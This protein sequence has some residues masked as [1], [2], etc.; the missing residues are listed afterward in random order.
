M[1]VNIS[2]RMCTSWVLSN[3][4]LAGLSTKRSCKLGTSLILKPPSRAAQHMGLEA[5]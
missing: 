1:A 5:D 3:V 4:S 2:S